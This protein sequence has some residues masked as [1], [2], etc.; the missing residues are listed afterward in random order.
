MEVIVEVDMVVVVVVELDVNVV[1]E[2]DVVVVA[3]VVTPGVVALLAEV[4]TLI[5][6]MDVVVL[7]VRPIL[8]DIMT[9]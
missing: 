3:E 8:M 2:V 6:D 7:V 1:A 9:M 4:V 5:K